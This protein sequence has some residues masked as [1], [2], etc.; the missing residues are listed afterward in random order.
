[1]IETNIEYE[2]LCAKILTKY[3]YFCLN[4]DNVPASWSLY[5]TQD[6][7]K[8]TLEKISKINQQLHDEHQCN[9]SN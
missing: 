9:R 2:H 5:T 7:F 4:S 6:K 8:N 1:M 3:F